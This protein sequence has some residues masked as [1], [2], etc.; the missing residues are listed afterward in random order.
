[1]HA[2]A[3]SFQES[4]GGDRNLIS[5]AKLFASDAIRRHTDE[6]MQIFGAQGLDEDGEVEVLRLHNASKVMQIFD[7]TSEIHETILGL[8]AAKLFGRG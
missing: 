2:A 6:A 3:H 1:M 5:M 8:E 7:G 4:D